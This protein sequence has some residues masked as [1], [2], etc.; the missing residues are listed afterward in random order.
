MAKHLLMT[1]YESFRLQKKDRRF[2]VMWDVAFLARKLVLMVL[3]VFS[4]NGIALYLVGAFLVFCILL[5]LKIKPF[6]RDLTNRLE[7][8]SLVTLC[9]LTVAN[10]FW[11]KQNTC[12]DDTLMSVFRVFFVYAE[13]VIICAPFLVA[14]FSVPLAYLLAF[15]CM[16]RDRHSKEGGDEH[17]SLRSTPSDEKDWHYPDD[18]KDNGNKAGEKKPVSR[19]TSTVSATG[20]VFNED[21]HWVGTQDNG[22]E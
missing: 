8:L 16:F 11:E 15:V 10:I 7:F 6:S 2:D 5:Q 21:G 3:V 1:L 18:E 17:Q 12:V 4:P 22:S 14:I 13:Y 20:L 9:F 19:K